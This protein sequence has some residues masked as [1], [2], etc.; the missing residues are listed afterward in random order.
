MD[1]EAVTRRQ[2]PPDPWAE[3]DNIP[4]NDPGFSRRMLEEHLTQDHDRA[5]RRFE[6]IDRQ[7]GWI[8]SEVLQGTAAKILE[9][10]CGPGL[11]TSRLARLGHTCVGI[12]YAPAAIEYA[13]EEASSE[14]SLNNCRF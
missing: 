1:L 10:T 11:Y 8:H 4:W 7:V 14:V 13:S 5:S 6:T 2:L 3:G 9:L 12:D